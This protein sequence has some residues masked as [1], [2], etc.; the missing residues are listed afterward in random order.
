VKRR[1]LISGVL[2]LLCHAALLFGFRI[3]S[4]P[5]PLPM[6]D[7]AVEVSL[8]ASIADP[9]STPEPPA[10]ISTPPPPPEPPL[11]PPEPVPQPEPVPERVREPAPT[12]PKPERRHTPSKP[13][14]A[15]A[16]PSTSAQPGSV[17][18]IPGGTSARP[19]GPTTGARPRSNPRPVYPPEARRLNQQ[20]RVMVVAQVSADGRATSVS[21]LRS[22]GFPLLDAAAVNAVRR[23]TFV[24]AQSAG[25]AIPSRVEVPVSF[26]LTQR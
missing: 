23:W 4:L 2:A 1:W 13:A 19:A 25:L 10:P 21:L 7:I 6:S 20:G 9:A 5:L 17:A 3:G 24:P 26:S 15:A 14:R 18:A 12:T 16:S 11:P 22:S 8:I